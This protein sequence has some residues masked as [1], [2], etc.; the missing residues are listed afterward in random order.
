MPINIGSATLV[1]RRSFRPSLPAQSYSITGKRY[2]E[3]FQISTIKADLSN[4]RP[5]MV[6]GRSPDDNSL[7]Y[8]LDFEVEIV[9]DSINLRANIIQEVSVSKSA[10]LS[11]EQQNIIKGKKYGDA[12]FD[13]DDNG[14]WRQRR[15]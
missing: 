15:T 10:I 14:E 12:V 13:L 9:F 3:F 1:V 8:R 2:D 11:A 7:F 4:L 5:K 6:E